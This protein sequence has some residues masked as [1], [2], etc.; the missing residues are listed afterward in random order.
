V[1]DV[2]VV[3]LFDPDVEVEPVNPAPIVIV[4]DE[5]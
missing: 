1:P 5:G 4:N 2:I 3:I